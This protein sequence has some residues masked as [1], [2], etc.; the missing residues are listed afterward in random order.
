MSVERLSGETCLCVL[1]LSVCPPPHLVSGPLGPAGLIFASPVSAVWAGSST[2]SYAPVGPQQ[3]GRP[4]Q[5]ACE[6][7]VSWSFWLCCSRPH[8]FCLLGSQ[9]LG[10]VSFPPSVSNHPGWT[11]FLNLKLTLML[12]LKSCSAVSQ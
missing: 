9:H 7:R 12:M 2:A 4:Q 6:L 3:D 10:S 8:V 11:S 5:P 1:S